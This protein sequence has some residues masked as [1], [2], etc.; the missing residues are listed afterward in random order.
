MKK[1]NLIN[2]RG[3]RKKIFSQDELEKLDLKAKQRI[4]LREM[5][6]LTEK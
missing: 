3:M 6:K 4:A 5:K 1:E 2:W